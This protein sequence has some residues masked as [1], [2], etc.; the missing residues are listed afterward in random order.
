MVD[1]CKRRVLAAW[2]S[3]SLG[4]GLGRIM[5]AA[6]QFEVLLEVDGSDEKG[7]EGVLCVH[8]LG[9]SMSS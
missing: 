9:D 7:A 5:V 6:R 1:T 3:W 8:G 2:A 4:D